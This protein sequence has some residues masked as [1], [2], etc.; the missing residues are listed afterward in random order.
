MNS[1]AAILSARINTELA[2]LKLVVE[3]TLQA[4]GKAS[5]QND[6]FYLDSVALN[7]HS[8]YSGLER[9]FAKLASTIDGAVPNAANWHQELL[10]QMQ[11]EIPSI[12]PAVI[13]CQLKE[14]LEEYRGFRH[15]VRNVYTYHLKPE[16]LRLLVNNLEDTFSL[17]SKELNEFLQYLEKVDD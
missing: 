11:A 1:Q 9:I 13:S 15:V 2:A 6:D 4:W 3:R 10:T 17:A 12:R 14:T 5:Q 7:L 8:F 16:K